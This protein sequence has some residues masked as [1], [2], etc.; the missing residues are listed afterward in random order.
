MSRASTQGEAEAASGRA[1]SLLASE[2][3]AGFR[4]TCSTQPRSDCRFE[5]DYDSTAGESRPVA[6]HAFVN[7]VER[8]ASDVVRLKLELA[9][10]DWLD[11]Q[12]GQFIQVTV[13]G[14]ELVRRYSM[15]STPAALPELELLIRLLP[16]GVM[17]DWL[18]GRAAVDDVLQIEGPYGSFF[19]RDHAKAS[20]VMIAGG[21]GLAPIQSMLDVIRAKSGIKPRIVLSFGCSDEDT[22]FNLEEL[23]LRALWMPTLD[24]RISVD[25]GT[26]RDDLRIGNPVE[27]IA[28]EDI[29]AKTVAYLCGPPA[30]IEAA[31]ARLEALGVN[32]ENIHAEQFVAME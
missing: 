10:G 14:T 30:M 6:A 4:L 23:E 26:A 18:T 20:H 1:T 13:P 27:A 5:F 3:D 15:S 8:I 22:L 31:H 12:A 2:R 28:P 32:P 19:L 11:F 16:D 25:R 9:D 17:S 21:T 7:A 29:D 24:V